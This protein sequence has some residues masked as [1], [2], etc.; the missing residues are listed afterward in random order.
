MKLFDYDD[1]NIESIYS[2]A[3]QLEGMT[4]HEILNEYEKSPYKSY[5]DNKRNSNTMVVK[6]QSGT[7]TVAPSFNEN[8]K[9]QLG[10]L[11][12]KYYFG[13]DPNG[14]QEADFNKTGLELKQTP[15]DINKKGEYKAGERLSITNI[16]YN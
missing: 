9:G 15:I 12:E 10:N 14:K 7:Y 3:K 5:E 6:E 4:F 2:Y 11:I 1:S 8:A 16:S 13:Y